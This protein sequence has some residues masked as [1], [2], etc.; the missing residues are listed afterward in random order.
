[1]PLHVARR[2]MVAA[3]MWLG[4]WLC[5]TVGAPDA[6]QAQA[7][8][9]EPQVSA[10]EGKLFIGTYGGDIRVVDEATGKI[11]E[12]IPLK[13][14]LARSLLPSADRTRFYVLDSTYEKIE[15]IDIATRKSLRD[16]S[17]RQGNRRLRVVSMVADPGNQYLILLT[18]LA[19][20]L[21]DRWEIGPAQLQQFDL[22]SGQITRTIPWPRG[23]ERETVNLRFSPDGS[24]LFMFGDEVIILETR[25]FTEVESWPLST[26]AESGVGRITLGPV[27]DFYDD[28]GTFTGLF[29]QQDPVQKRRIMG[30]GRVNL[31][32]RSVDFKPLGPAE[33]V[34]FAQ[35]PDRK[36]AYGIKTDI[37]RWEFWTFDL[38]KGSVVSRGEF[39]SRPRVVPRVSSNGKVIYVYVAG[40]TIDLYEA[41]TYRYLRTIH[42]NA[43]QTT[44]MFVVP[45]AVPARTAR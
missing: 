13:V 36:R 33:N 12:R 8:R 1:M 29:V 2:R 4:L 34:S 41:A 15:V 5:L 9:P 42:L 19:T 14:G 17:L 18:R 26:P 30:I 24:S 40:D 37:G 6:A 44:E 20:K 45:P 21:V 25:G 3:G 38:E 23:E 39:Q 11:E 43:D 31:T 10:G 22:A 16:Y 7:R 28:P 35:A 32:A 27:H